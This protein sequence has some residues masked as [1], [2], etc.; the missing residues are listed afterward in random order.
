MNKL[1]ASLFLGALVL[2]I[3]YFGVYDFYAMMADSIGVGWALAGAAL[4]AAGTV[5]I[6]AV[7]TTMIR[8]QPPRLNDVTEE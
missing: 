1:R 2:F 8:S 4:I 5:V 6:A 7:G 3:A